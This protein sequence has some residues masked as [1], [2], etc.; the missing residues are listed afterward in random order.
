MNSFRSRRTALRLLA[1]TGVCGGITAQA[2][3]GENQCSSHSDHVTWVV[4]SLERMQT[5]E[6]GMTRKQLLRIFTTEGGIST[7]KQ[8]TFVSRDC[9]YFKVNVTFR[10]ETASSA[11]SEHP[12]WLKEMDDD[13]ITTISGPFLQFSIMD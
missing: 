4:E 5:I 8:R 3:L 2:S 7:A 12:D 6:P 11:G 13:V 10:R 1:A 9:P